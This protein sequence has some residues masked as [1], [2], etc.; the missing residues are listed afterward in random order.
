MS[1]ACVVDLQLRIEALQG[2]AL[3]LTVFQGLAKFCFCLFDLDWLVGSLLSGLEFPAVVCSQ[4]EF[5]CDVTSHS[6]PCSETVVAPI[7][8]KQQDSRF[9]SW[10]LQVPMLQ[11]ASVWS[12]AL[13]TGDQPLKAAIQHSHSDTQQGLCAWFSLSNPGSF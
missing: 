8:P 3:Y 7:P 12:A 1:A 10:S 4:P 9:H 6:W 11:Q 13:M 2:V 5:D